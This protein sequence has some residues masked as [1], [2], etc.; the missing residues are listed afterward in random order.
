MRPALA[1]I[2]DADLP[3]AKLSQ[4]DL[5]KVKELRVQI[6]DLASVGQEEEARDLEEQA[7]KILGYQKLWLKCGPGSFTWMR[8]QALPRS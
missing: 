1:V 8:L 6:R 7:M 5:A 4:I 2:I 3:E